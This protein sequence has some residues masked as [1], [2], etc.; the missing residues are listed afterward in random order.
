MIDSLLKRIS[1]IEKPCDI[2]GAID[3]VPGMYF[4]NDELKNLDQNPQNYR[5]DY[6]SSLE[7]K[8]LQFGLS[9]PQPRIIQWLALWFF[10]SGNPD[11]KTFITSG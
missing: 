1:L 11:P 2:W 6:K 3:L 8:V 10:R 7:K 5:V 4:S 9:L